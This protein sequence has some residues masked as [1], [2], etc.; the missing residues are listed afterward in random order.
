MRERAGA[1]AWHGGM[2]V[3]GGALRMQAALA[4]QDRN[5]PRVKC[6]QCYPTAPAD[7]PGSGPAQARR[8]RCEY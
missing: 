6:G 5:P 3:Q 7:L 1:V 8:E 2:R 4:D